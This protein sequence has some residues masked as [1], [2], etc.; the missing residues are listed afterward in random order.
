MDENG[1]EREVYGLA[2]VNVES[3]AYI[4]ADNIPK[5]ISFPDN[6]AVLEFTND[7]TKG[8]MFARYK[9]ESSKEVSLSVGEH[10]HD[11]LGVCL[12]VTRIKGA[13]RQPK[14]EKVTTPIAKLDK[15]T[16]LE[17][18]KYLILVGG[19]VANELT[20]QLQEEGK[21]NIDNES[22]PTLQVIDD[23]ILVVAGGDRHRTREAALHLIENY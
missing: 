4:T 19:P 11:V 14:P 7:G 1:R 21:V 16:S 18:D 12:E 17:T 23:R 5:E 15:E 10:R 2:L 13:I 9:K 6:Y 22:S 3:G 20:R 8:R